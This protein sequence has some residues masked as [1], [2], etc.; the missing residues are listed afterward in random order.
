MAH[1]RAY[2]LRQRTGATVGVGVTGIAGPSGAT[3]RKPVGLV[4]VAVSDAQKTE[5]VSRTF[6]G[7]RQ[8]VR[9]YT[10]QLALDLVRHRLM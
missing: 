3:E 9:E 6:R 7:D 4:Y 5:V 1:A 2:G 10:A 8:R